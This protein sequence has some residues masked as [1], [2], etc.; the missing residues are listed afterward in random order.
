MD[1]TRKQHFLNAALFWTLTGALM[2]FFG[3][4]WIWLGFGAQT[5]GLLAFLCAALGLLKGHFVIGKSALRSIV[6]IQN[7]PERSPFYQLF[8]KGTWILIL[9]MMSLGMIIRFL[10]I[11]KAYRGL[12]LAAIGIALLWASRCFWK[13]AVGGRSP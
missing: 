6:R 3:F 8:S 10:H 5:A 11:E 1:V 7:M 13:A 12:V 4:K 9:G 2:G